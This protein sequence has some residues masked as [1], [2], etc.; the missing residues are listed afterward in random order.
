MQKIFTFLFVVLGFLNNAFTNDISFQALAPEEVVTGERFQVSFQISARPSSFKAPE[1]SGFRVISGPNQS[2]STSVQIINNQTTRTATFTYSYILES[3][4]EGT[5]D[6]APATAIIDGKGHRSNELSIKAVKASQQQRG[7]SSQQTQPSQGGQIQQRASADDLF[8]RASVSKTNPYQGE[9][10]IITYRLYTRVSVSQYSVDQLPSFRNFWSENL[11]PS[12]N[13]Q[14]STEVLNGKTYRVAEIRRIAIFPQRSGELTLDPLEVELIVNLPAQRDRRSLFDEFFGG[15]SRQVRQMVASNRV[16]LN[17]QPLPAQNRPANFSGMVGSDFSIEASV[18]PTELQINDA[19]TLKFTVSGR[20]NLK[21]IETPEFNFPA[22]LEV[23][24]PNINDNIR[25]TLSGISGSRTF[26]YLMIPR[27]GGE[28]VIPSLDFVYFD[29]AEKRYITR[30]T[31]EFTIQV[32]GSSSP[33]VSSG[34]TQEDIQMLGQDIRFIKTG[35]VTFQQPG[36]SF[37]GSPLFFILIIGQV[38]L[39][40][41]FLI[42][43]RNQIKLRSNQQLLRTRKAEKLARKRLKK[44]KGYLQQKNENSFYDEI[45]KA[46]WG[47]LSDKLSIPVSIL[48][49]ENVEGAFKTKRVSGELSENF[50]QTLDDCDFAR[51]APGE[52]EDKMEDIFQ[53]ALETIVMIEKELRNK[54]TAS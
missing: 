42:I 16:N 38:L 36:E 49:K 21:M 43:L 37:Y 39:F 26:S 29:P 54:K 23:F 47:Y 35:N 3:T 41:V 24:D 1:F 44:A 12:G 22:N 45:S 8:I 9:Q 25:N 2:S 31:S 30:Q 13:P 27:T 33:Q 15:A 17:V 40:I 46:L 48:N 53:K 50:I 14:T 6:I 11:T 51:F 4:E 7:S 28:F 32:E 5:F 20:G 34:G 10:I 18:S 19:A 52:K